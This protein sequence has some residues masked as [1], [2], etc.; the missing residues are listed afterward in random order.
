MRDRRSAKLYITAGV[1]A[2]LFLILAFLVASGSTLAFDTTIRNGI[3]A[4]AGPAL[5]ETAHA[6]S[7]VGSAFVWL[8]AL[9]IAMAAFWIMGDRRGAIGLA[10]VMAGATL[11]DNGLK[12]AFHRVRPEVFFG[13]LPN[14]YSFPSGHALFNFCFYGALAVILASRERRP[15]LRVA[16]WIAAALVVLG[17]GLSRIYLGVH[18]PSDVLAGFLAGG[19]WL[20]FV[21]GT[22]L[23]QHTR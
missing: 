2:P 3:H 10:I 19:A 6:L 7:F 14:T 8:L 5:T 21:G 23:L 11:L 16:L 9:A 4:W 20:S 17:I 18:Y 22:G 15:G 13:A 12:L 1:C